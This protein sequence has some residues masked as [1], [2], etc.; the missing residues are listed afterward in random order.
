[1]ACSTTPGASI[2]SG[3]V[4]NA[5]AWGSVVT[6]AASCWAYPRPTTPAKIDNSQNS[7]SVTSAPTNKE[8]SA[9]C[10]AAG[11]AACG[12][13]VATPVSQPP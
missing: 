4:L 3:V 8:R 10:H 11:S 2:P 13:S 6:D 5:V 7:A 9:R 1:M 12:T